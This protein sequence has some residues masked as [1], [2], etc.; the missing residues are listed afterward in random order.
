MGRLLPLRLK[1]AEALLVD[2]RHHIGGGRKPAFRRAAQQF[3]GFPA[4]IAL[5]I[6][7]NGRGPGHGQLRQAGSDRRILIQPRRPDVREVGIVQHQNLLEAE[8][9]LLPGHRH[10]EGGVD[11][12]HHQGLADFQAMM[13]QP[14][15]QPGG[16]RRGG[17]GLAGEIGLIGSGGDGH[18]AAAHQELVDGEQLLFGEGGRVRQHQQIGRFRHGPLGQIGGRHAEVVFKGAAQLDELIAAHALLGHVGRRRFRRHQ[19]DAAQQP[20][21]EAFQPFLDGALGGLRRQGFRQRNLHDGLAIVDGQVEVEEIGVE[22]AGRHGLES[23]VGGNLPGQAAVPGL[24]VQKFH[25]QLAVAFGRQLIQHPGQQ[26]AK[27]GQ[28]LGQLGI[29]GNIAGELHRLLNVGEQAAAALEAVQ[30]FLDA[31]GQ[32]VFRVAQLHIQIRFAAHLHLDQ[33]AEAQHLVLV[34]VAQQHIEI[35]I[36]QAR[37][38]AV[39]HLEGHGANAVLGVRL[40]LQFRVFG[41]VDDLHPE[42]AAPGHFELREQIPHARHQRGQ[43]RMGLGAEIAADQ[44][45]FPQLRQ[46]APGGI[47]NRIDA[48]FGH[49]DAQGGQGR[50]PQV[51]RQQVGRQ[52]RRAPAPG[53]MPPT[54]PVARPALHFQRIDIQRQEQAGQGEVVVE[55][56]QIQHAPGD[57][58]E[59]GA[60]ADAAEEI[61]QGAGHQVRQHR[62]AGQIEGAAGEAGQ[63]QADDLAVGAGADEQADGDIGPTQ[64]RRRQVAG[65]HRPP[66]QIR[67]IGDADRQRQ[68]QRQGDAQQGPAGQEL[69]QHEMPGVGRGGEQELHGAGAP[70]LAPHAHGQG[71]GQEDEQH[72]HPLEHGA[73]IGHIAGEPGFYPEEYEQGDR[74]KGG[75]KEIGRGGREEQRQFLAR[76]SAGHGE[77]SL[78]IVAHRPSLRSR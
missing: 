74:Q 29:P 1:A 39:R 53:G 36:D 62:A 33:V 2:A 4:G 14:A 35:G 8:A 34:A 49:I 10:R 52:Q 9:S 45:G 3:D 6:Q 65:H 78:P 16:A 67:Q 66:I 15:F 73:H 57:G 59:P 27:L 12:V 44:Q 55:V 25:G 54:V 71:G 38:V 61:R 31:A 7:E 30:N 47:G 56:A 42:V 41:R 19:G 72:R 50:Q 28:R 69:A 64:E 17:Q 20:G 22:Q 43:Q 5:L 46:I 51:G 63:D 13:G 75:Q 11:R 77:P 68:S 58:L 23:V 32:V 76:N 48:A 26:A 70:L 24:R 21:G 40:V 37:L 60:G 18:R